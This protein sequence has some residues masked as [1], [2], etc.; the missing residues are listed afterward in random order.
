MTIAHM[1][2]GLLQKRSCKQN[3]FSAIV[4]LLCL[5]ANLCGTLDSYAE[6][7]QTAIAMNVENDAF[8][9]KDENYTAGLSLVL[10][11]NNKGLLGDFW[12]LFGTDT[13]FKSSSYEIAQLLFTPTEL[14]ST[15]PDPKD[16]PYAGILYLG[17]TTHHQTQSALQTL[18]LIVGVIG[19]Y[20]LGEAGQEAAHHLFQ[21]RLP[22]GWSHQLKNEPLLDL[23]YEYRHKFDITEYVGNL[24]VQLFPICSAML[25]NYLT[26]GHFEGQVRIGYNLPESAG[27]TT[28]RGIGTVPI[29]NNHRNKHQWGAY[30][31]GGAGGD[32]VARDITLDGNTFEDSPRV[33]KRVFVPFGELGVS[34][35]AGRVKTSFTYVI[36]GKEFF[37]QREVEKYGAVNLTYFY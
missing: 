30:F 25:G 11:R 32:L 3:F 23:Q 5:L 24:G 27:D 34:I 29:F 21:N 37:G 36:V 19:P 18:K 2:F 26:K 8:Y 20:S 15:V 16:R 14:Y 35:M 7:P 9:G 4:L 12:N 6:Q 33:K 17:L 10:S 13:G 1:T 31:F 22:Q 28:I